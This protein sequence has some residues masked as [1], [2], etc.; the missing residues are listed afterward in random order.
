MRLVLVLVAAVLLIGCI[1]VDTTREVH[2]SAP[3]PTPP[4]LNSPEAAGTVTVLETSPA[5][6]AT[7]V[8]FGYENS[9]AMTLVRVTVRCRGF[10]KDGFQV[11]VQD[12][13]IEGAV[14]GPIDP[15]FKIRKRIDLFS[16]AIAS[17][18]CGVYRA[19]AR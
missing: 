14:E 6:N 12:V 18:T 8:S 13:T 1:A 3:P 16:S 19:E 10:D 7:F 9:T 17:V 15:G 11:A 4:I 5:G 2:T